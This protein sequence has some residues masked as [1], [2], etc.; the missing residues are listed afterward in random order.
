M[1]DGVLGVLVEVLKER[2]RQDAKWGEQNHPDVGRASAQ[3]PDGVADYH[4]VPNA[5]RAK[6]ICS[7]RARNGVVSF[8]DIAVEELCE[9]IEAAA[10]GDENAVRTEVIQ[11]AAVCV[12]W[13][14]A[15]DRREA[16]P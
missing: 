13:V 3:T 16:T 8:A 5:N 14:Q 4:E 9:A 11:L 1:S 2:A 15:I 7:T 12:Q 10:L 6:W